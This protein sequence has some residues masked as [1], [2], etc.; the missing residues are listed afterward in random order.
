VSLYRGWRVVLA[1]GI[2]ASFSW[3]LGFY[4]LGVYLHALSRWCL[5]AL[6]GRRR[7]LGPV[8]TDAAATSRY[9]GGLT[10]SRLTCVRPARVSLPSAPVTALK[11][12][13]LPA[14]VSAP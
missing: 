11:N 4:G 14:W 13:C 1:C 6:K 7:R 10:P 2:I 8:G 9:I 12:A 3:G 5:V